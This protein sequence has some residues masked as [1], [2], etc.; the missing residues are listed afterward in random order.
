MSW[1]TLLLALLAGCGKQEAPPYKA[2]SL[3]VSL[4][5][6]QAYENNDQE[7]AARKL[8]RLTDIM[9]D[10]PGIFELTEDQINQSALSTAE[11]PL[12]DRR[13][14]GSKRSDCYCY[15]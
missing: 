1:V 5:L 10:A 14:A 4:E 11:N 15:S 12:A 6:L 8:E 9:P 3:N 2:V 13:V 7:L